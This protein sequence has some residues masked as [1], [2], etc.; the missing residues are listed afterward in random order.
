MGSVYSFNTFTVS[1]HC[2]NIV[3]IRGAPIGQCLKSPPQDD[4]FPC[5]IPFSTKWTWQKFKEIWEQH[6]QQMSWEGKFKRCSMGCCYIYPENNRL[7]DNSF[8]VTGQEGSYF[9]FFEQ[10]HPLQFP[11]QPHV[12]CESSI[13]LLDSYWNFR[14][15][16]KITKFTFPLIYA[17][18][19]VPKS[20][21]HNYG[22]ATD[23]KLKI[24][25]AFVLE[26]TS[27]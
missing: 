2:Q 3:I 26:G 21:S 15:T 4:F 14:Y 19:I 7:C 24:V 18:K 20:I 17:T 12:Y 13:K 22:G 11:C 16:P 6:L 5:S 25:F 8:S 1:L 27:F 9:G 10:R 23:Q